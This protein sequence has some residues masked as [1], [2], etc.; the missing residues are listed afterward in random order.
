M[1]VFSQCKIQSEKTSG[2]NLLPDTL[3]ALQLSARNIVIPI[4][5]LHVQCYQGPGGKTK[6]LWFKRK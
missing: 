1:F 3:K 2:L 6:C 4:Q 5:V